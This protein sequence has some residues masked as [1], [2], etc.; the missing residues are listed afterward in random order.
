MGEML[1]GGNPFQVRF[2]ADSRAVTCIRNEVINGCGLSRIF[3]EVFKFYRHFLQG[4]QSPV[5]R[6]ADLLQ[7]VIVSL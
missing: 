1:H 7:P 3:M 4:E 5:H 2:H 6:D